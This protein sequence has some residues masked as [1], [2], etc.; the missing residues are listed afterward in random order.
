M[1]WQDFKVRKSFAWL[2]NAE[3]IRDAEQRGILLIPLQKRGC[4]GI[5]AE[6]MELNH[7]IFMV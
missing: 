4:L 2:L 3:V 7:Q 5:F 1:L 6:I